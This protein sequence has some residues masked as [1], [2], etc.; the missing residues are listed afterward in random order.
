MTDADAVEAVVTTGITSAVREGDETVGHVLLLD[1][2]EGLGFREVLDDVEELDGFTAVLESSPGSFH[3][4]NLTVRSLEETALLKLSLQDDDLHAGT[5]YRAGR[6]VARIG[7]KM[8]VG[9][10]GEQRLYKEAPKLRGCWFN[11]TDAE[12]SQ[13]H[14]TLLSNTYEEA[15]ARAYPLMSDGEA[16]TVGDGLGASRYMTGTDA[17]KKAWREAR[18]APMGDESDGGESA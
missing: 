3:V 7:P 18:V 9:A 6:W 1:Y 5:G 10:D 16:W 17:A 11:E 4:W 14:L 13:P 15:E 2:D 12:Q 8:I